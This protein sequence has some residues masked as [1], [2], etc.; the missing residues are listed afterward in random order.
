MR[1]ESRDLVT[2]GGLLLLSVIWGVNFTV[3]KGVLDILDPLALNALRFP[4]ASL[5]LAAVLARSDSSVRPRSA[6]ILPLVALAVLGNV[7]YQMCFVLGIDATLA[8]NA[9]LLLAT[10]PVWVV[11]LSAA[12]GHERPTAPVAAGI[13]ATVL[14]MGLVVVGR[15]DVVSL[16]GETLVGD[17]LMILAALLWAA[18]TVGARDLV[19]RYGSIR[20]T[21]WT[22][23]IGTPFLVVAGVP[24]L[25]SVAWGDVPPW[26]WIGVVYSG[27][28]S[29][30]VA[31]LLWYRGVRR[32]GNSRTAVYSN[33]VPV[34]AILTAWIWLGEVP[35][36]LQLVGAAVILAG[37]TGTR[38]ARAPQSPEPSSRR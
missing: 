32:L 8:G 24:S 12:A 1:F 4:M 23:W 35:R 38:A 18:Y 30:G 6:D 26:A 36:P 25:S 3:V 14:G 2:D 5:V 22:L 29:V 34:S 16:G 20:I 27:V 9:S 15:G 33:L 31:Y 37:L 21:A 7:V 19:H 13:A 11:L 17:G 10:S 28:F